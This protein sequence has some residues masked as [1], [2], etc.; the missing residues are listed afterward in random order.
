MR[1]LALGGAVLAA[2][3]TL[4]ACGSS[5]TTESGPAATAGGDA[6]DAGSVGGD[7]YVFLP[8]SL[9]NPY[10]VDARKG[11]EDQAKKLGVKA[12]FLGPD[13]DDAAAQVAIFESVLSKKPAGIAVSPNDPASVTNIVA[14]AREA[15]IPVI[16]WDGPVP[17]SE[18]LGYIGTDNVTAG[19]RQA[20]ALVQAMG[21]EGK[22]AVI[23]GSLSAPNLNQRLEGLKKGLA[24]YPGIEI[25]ATEESGESVADAQGKAETVLQAN[26]DLKGMAG[27]GGS[28]T[29]GI[30]GALKSGGQCGKIK[31]VGFDVVPQGVQGM[32]DGCVDALIAQRPFGMTAKALKILVDFNQDKSKLEDGFNVDTGVE[33]VTPDNLEEFQSSGPK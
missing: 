1:S 20:E 9:N 8:K 25:V 17:D 30:A 13:N 33:V 10:W 19:E 22:V 16:A 31:A 28:D 7:T 26:P 29:P 11:M 15:G 5:T 21:E 6:A 23:I 27:I 2:T 4:T 18:V 24:E 12:Q 3:L 14:Q 32:K